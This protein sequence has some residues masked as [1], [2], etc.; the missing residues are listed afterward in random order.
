MP[1]RWDIGES[2]GL[3]D[4]VDGEGSH[5][6]SDL[7]TGSSLF[8]AAG[9]CSWLVL[10]RGDGVAKN[11]IES[12]STDPSVTGVG[13]CTPPLSSGLRAPPTHLSREVLNSGDSIRSSVECGS[14]VWKTNAVDF[15][16]VIGDITS[17]TSDGKDV[18]EELDDKAE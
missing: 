7:L 1:P 12:A 2:R 18:L 16:G 13:L 3:A 9:S 5:S 8:T 10:L 14:F 11:S 6:S 17:F 15:P 4:S